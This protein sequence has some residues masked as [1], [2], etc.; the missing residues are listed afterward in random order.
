MA[1]ISKLDGIIGNKEMAERNSIE[2]KGS[3]LE[4]YRNLVQASL[5]YFIQSPVMR[6]K[7]DDFDSLE[8]WKSMKLIAEEN[9]KKGRLG[10]LKQWYKDLTDVP[11]ETEDQNFEK[12]IFTHTGYIISLNREREREIK[13]IE[14]RGLIRNDDEFRTIMDLV[15]SLCQEKNIDIRRI[16]VLNSILGEY[17][18]GH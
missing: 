5:D 15:N 4:K 2:Q 6:I 11:R 8:H 16:E 17:E 7:T 18:K 3:E 1:Y 13:G 10:R 9:Y 12:F 14:K